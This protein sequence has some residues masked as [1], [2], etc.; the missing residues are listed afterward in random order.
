MSNTNQQPKPNAKA[1]LPIALF[2][3]LYLGNGIYFQ[4]ISPIEGQMGFYV[5]S[6]V[7][8]FTLLKL[9]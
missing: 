9:E 4:Y 2:L 7:L 6:V 1:L 3:I 8:S 5:V